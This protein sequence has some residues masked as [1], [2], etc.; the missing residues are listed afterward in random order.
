ML[1]GGIYVIQVSSSRCGYNYSQIRTNIPRGE[2]QGVR[3]EVNYQC[4]C[5]VILDFFFEPTAR[6][7]EQCYL[8]VASRTQRTWLSTLYL[9]NPPIQCRNRRSYRI[10]IVTPSGIFFQHV[11]R[12]M[13]QAVDDH[14]HRQTTF[15][16]SLNIN[17]LSIID[18][19]S[20]LAFASIENTQTN[21][22]SL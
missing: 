18:D 20:Y 4:A 5:L 1:L 14:W 21:F 2:R 3:S 6:S 13:T 12:I 7:T 11:F 10:G 16:Q 17:K 15:L 9:S 8:Y 22:Q 19:S